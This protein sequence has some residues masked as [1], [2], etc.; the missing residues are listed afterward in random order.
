MKKVYLLLS[1]IALFGTAIAQ[2]NVGINTNDPKSTFDVNGNLALRE[3]PSLVLS[4]GGA[5]GGVNDNIVLPD[6]TGLT[7][8]KASFYRITGPTA[9][10]S[11]YG[12]VPNSGADG[13]L[14]TLMNTTTN[15]MTVKNNASSIAA[16]SIKTLSGIDMVTVAGMSSITLQYNKTDARW[17]V[18]GSEN[19][20]VSSTSLPTKD[21]V[22]GTGSAI[23]VVNGANQVVGGGN[24][25]VDVQ[26]NSLGQKGIVPGPTGLNSSQVWGTDGGGNPAWAKVQNAQMQNSSV[27]VNT[28]TGLSGGGSVALGGT[29]NLTNTA[30]DQT[31]TL[32][33]G[34]GISATGTYPN[35]TI[36]NTGDLSTSNEGSLTV[37]AGTA[38]TSLISSNTTGSTPV[39]LQ[40]GS[41]V[42]LSETGNTITI[43]SSN[44]GGT[45][46]NIITTAPITGGPITTTGTISLTQLGDV[47]GSTGISVI[48]G[49]DKLPGSADITINNTGVTSIAGTPNQVIVN[50]ATGAVTVSTPQ[51]IH[52]GANVTFNS[53]TAP[54][55]IFGRINVIDTR[56]SD[57]APNTFDNEVAFEF[58]ARGSIAGTPGSGTY[59]GLM[60]LAP[61]GDNS[62]DLHHQLFFNNGGI[63]YRTGQPDNTSWN[64]WSQLLTSGNISSNINGTT[65]YVPK[66][67][68][69]NTIGNS[70]VYD[71]GSGIGIGTT[72]SA[73]LHVSGG[74]MI[75]GTNGVTSNT[76]TLTILEDGDAQTNFGAYP[77]QWTSALQIQDNTTNR[78]VW[79]SPL[80]N[81]SGANA[82][83]VSAGSGFDVYTNTSTQAMS[84]S[85]AGAATFPSLSAGGLVKS[86]GGTL[87]VAGAA[88][89][90]AGSGNYIQNQ[91]GGAQGANFWVSGEGRVG[92]WLRNSNAGQG[93]YNEATGRHFY[94][95]SSS[96]WTTASANGMIFRNGLGGTIVG[97]TYWDGTAGSN[98][99]GLL[100]PS[101][102]WRYRVDNSNTEAYGGFYNYTAYNQFTYDRDNTG[103][104]MDMNNSSYFNVTTGNEV[105]TNN[106]FRVNSSGG[107]YWQ[108]YGGGWNMQ[109]GTWLRTYGNKAILASGG[110]A[111]YGNSVFGG[112]YG[113]N[114]RIY[115]NYDNVGAGGIMVADDGGFFDY[116]DGYIEYRGSTGLAVRVDNG[117]GGILMRMTNTGGGGLSDRRIITDNNAWGLVGA[118]GNAFWQFWGYSFNNAST[119]ESKKD[120]TEVSGAIA[121]KVMEDLDKMHPYLYR[122]N[123]ESDEMVEGQE[124]KY[125]PGLH[126]GLL[127]DESPDY[128][129]S[130][131]YDGVDIYAV[132]TLGV[133]AAKVN[134][135]DIKDIKGAMGWSDETMNIQ[136]FGSVNV[137]GESMWVD[138]DKAFSA[139][140]NGALPV[141]TV[142]GNKQT[143]EVY[144]T[145]KTDKGFRV[146]IAGD[147]NGLQ[148]DYIAM[149]K[150]KHASAKASEVPAETLSKMYVTAEQKKKAYEGTHKPENSIESIKEKAQKEAPAIQKQRHD[151]I[152]GSGM[153]AE[154]PAKPTF[155]VKK[156]AEEKRRKAEE[157]K[158]NYTPVPENGPA[159]NLGVASPSKENAPSER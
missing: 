72:G 15:V 143:G 10:F 156:D 158:K 88:D 33:S 148:L 48:G 137:T 121:A 76:R 99:Y 21:I 57:F 59:G 28:G 34:S 107:I 75:L 129:Q 147:Y 101:G 116:N 46:T 123:V 141:I 105:Y 16:N 71:N 9:A 82:R 86:V 64:G 25:V 130:Q 1:A 23:T 138:F 49:T 94:S 31:V 120:I 22:P 89:I 84:L 73:R 115:A 78:F 144:V 67:T 131:S 14:V 117:A 139:K 118:S 98:N 41:N 110:V 2:K 153:Q 81:A 106:W 114:P 142:T 63:F 58:K 32:T 92:A 30:P 55:D 3:G 122:Y 77:G 85:A 38:T 93:L 135:E 100:S 6:I 91:Y 80:D 4:N 146:K 102:N 124:A 8:V 152:Y 108:A 103:Y 74:G 29:L 95:E 26:T 60:T 52:T 50:Q 111:G 45:V 61:W 12:V 150:V 35:F 159:K 27:T 157:D 127:V 149:A 17:Y 96:Y 136:D 104:Y 68:S 39:T 83:L 53:V 70:L 126:M 90:P 62:G 36:T 37:G 128:V 47:L 132:A 140:L 19:F 5:S 113:A 20:T 145:E 79:L 7:G 154:D 65:N 54:N 119:R 51:N 125:R 112:A 56:A 134:R 13:Q 155:D 44:S 151:E 97:Y 43:A 66:F 11:I 133:S 87:Q 40:A 109:D 69:A 24:V 42:T 18:I